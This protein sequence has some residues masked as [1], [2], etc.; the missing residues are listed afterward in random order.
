MSRQV[1]LLL[2]FGFLMFEVFPLH[3]EPISPVMTVARYRLEASIG[4]P[5]LGF[6]LIWNPV[7]WG[8]GRWPEMTSTYQADRWFLENHFRVER[9]FGDVTVFFNKINYYP[10]S[11]NKYGLPEWWSYGNGFGVKYNF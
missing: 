10:I 4:Y 2:L 3:N 1:V 8:D 5:V 9:A 11:G 6:N 7:V